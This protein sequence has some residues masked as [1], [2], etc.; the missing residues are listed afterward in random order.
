MAAPRF[1]AFAALLHIL[2]RVSSGGRKVWCGLLTKFKR[3]LAKVW[4]EILGKIKI[5][6]AKVWLEILTPYK[7]LTTMPVAICEDFLQHKRAG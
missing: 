7:G 5:E 6:M 3:T 1:L 2:A 4:S